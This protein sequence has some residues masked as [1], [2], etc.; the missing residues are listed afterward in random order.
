MLGLVGGA[1]TG[2]MAAAAPPTWRVL[3]EVDAVVSWG[4]AVLLLARSQTP[5]GWRRTAWCWTLTL[6]AAYAV[7]VLGQLTL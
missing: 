3:L 2:F 5:P 4:A 6:P 1:L 7:A